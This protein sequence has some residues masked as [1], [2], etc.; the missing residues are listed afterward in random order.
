[1]IQDIYRKK[2]ELIMLK[3]AHGMNHKEVENVQI[4]RKE[5]RNS[6]VSNNRPSDIE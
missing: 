3:I 2:N 1:M 6:N 4:G 5:R